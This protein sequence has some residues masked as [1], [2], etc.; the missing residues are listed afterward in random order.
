M[1]IKGYSKAKYN[2]KNFYGI[3]YHDNKGKRGTK[4]F[5]ETFKK[6]PYKLSM[7][8]GIWKRG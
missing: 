5:G 2:I 6:F 3:P 1:R 7:I 8:K 4:F